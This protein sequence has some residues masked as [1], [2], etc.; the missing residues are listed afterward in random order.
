MILPQQPISRPKLYEIVAEKLEQMI[1]SGELKPGDAL[2]SERDIMTAFQIGRPAVRE[3]F[4]SLQSKGLITT[5][6]GRR[7]RVT[8][9]SVEKVIASLDAIVGMVLG[10]QQSLRNLYDARIFIEM[11]MA[12]NA[13]KNITDEQ[14][15]SLKNALDANRT[16]IGDREAFIASD[17]TFHKVLFMIPDNPVFNSVYTVLM[18]WLLYRWSKIARNDSTETLAYEGHAALYE[19]IAQRDPDAAEAR[20]QDHLQSSWSIWSRRNE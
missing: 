12:R 20:M 2:P 9:P 3:A 6:S 4:L 5:E 16:A 14:L 10:D 7:A 19:A 8:S 1:V 17:V 11:A 15:A 18:N 13:A